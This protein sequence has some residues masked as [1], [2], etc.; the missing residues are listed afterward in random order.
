MTT[1]N[2]EMRMG[3]FIPFKS[4]EMAKKALILINKK[5]GYGGWLET[6]DV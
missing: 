1:E 6:V 2:K 4:E 3:V 5:C